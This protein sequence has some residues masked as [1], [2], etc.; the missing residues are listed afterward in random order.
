M[1]QTAEGK[2]QDRAGKD[3]AGRERKGRHGRF[4]GKVMLSV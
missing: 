4:S 1:R 2:A 3:P